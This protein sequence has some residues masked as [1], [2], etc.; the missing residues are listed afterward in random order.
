MQG[1]DLSRAKRKF[2]LLTHHVSTAELHLESLKGRRHK[3][4]KDLKSS[5]VTPPKHLIT[6]SH[7]ASLFLGCIA[8]RHLSFHVFK[9]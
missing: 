7:D 9:S 2:F 1:Q 5:I 8:F 3:S 4:H 6:S